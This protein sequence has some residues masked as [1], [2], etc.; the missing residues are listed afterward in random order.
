M[1]TARGGKDKDKDG[2]GNKG[3]VAHQ[4]EGFNRGTSHEQSESCVC[5]GLV[6]SKKN[7]KKNRVL[8]WGM[9]KNKRSRE[10]SGQKK[11]LN[12]GYGS[13]P[14]KCPL[15]DQVLGR[16]WRE[17]GEAL[18]TKQGTKKD[19]DYGGMGPEPVTKQKNKKKRK[20]LKQ[21]VRGHVLQV[22]GVQFEEYGVQPPELKIPGEIGDC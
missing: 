22:Q 1:A 6:P 20:K 16:G 9:K 10:F 13:L 3:E 8:L 19:K 5:P 7:K 2:S 18:T 21:K 17:R 12:L 4:K 14:G 15:G 11:R